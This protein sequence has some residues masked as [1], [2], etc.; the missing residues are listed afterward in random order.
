M[1]KRMTKGNKEASIHV[2]ETTI[3]PDSNCR[4]LGLILDTKM[5]WLSH[6]EKIEARA[7]KSLGALSSLAGST[8]GTGYKGLRQIYQAVILPQMTHAA[9]TWYAPIEQEAGYRKRLVSKLEAIQRRAAKIITG[10]FKRTSTPALDVEAF[11]LPTR[12]SLDKL[13]GEAFL[14]L[15]AA[16]LHLALQ[17]ARRRRTWR[18]YQQEWEHLSARW[19]PL[20]RHEHRCKALL[21]EEALNKLEPTQPYLVPAW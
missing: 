14:R 5:N 19:S 13:T 12:Q 3:K 7:T 10:A 15:R 11:L 21:G 9:S 6:V 20:E 8:W 1:M 18:G 4:I 2:D 17:E 16:P